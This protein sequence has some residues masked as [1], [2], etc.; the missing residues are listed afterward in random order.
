MGLWP[1]ITDPNTA[2]FAKQALVAQLNGLEGERQRLAIEAKQKPPMAPTMLAAD[3]IV[4]RLKA[5]LADLSKVLEGKERD[6]ILARERVRSMVDKIIITPDLNGGG[7]V[8]LA[9]QRPWCALT[10]EG[11]LTRL[12]E[13]VDVPVERDIKHSLRTQTLL[14]VTDI[15]YRFYVD[16]K[17][18][19]PALAHVYPYLPILS[20]LL[21]SAQVPVTKGVFM[22]ALG[23]DLT[24]PE[25]EFKAIR[26]VVESTPARLSAD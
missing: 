10:V 16:F 7:A 18:E 11:S 13:M 26:G 1:L 12:L 6:A 8:D 17:P 20:Q 22:K 14:D 21:D 15:P 9:W 25:A 5:M 4:E 23:V 3:K 24:T 19:K 2:G